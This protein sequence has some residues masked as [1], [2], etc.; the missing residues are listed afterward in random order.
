MEHPPAVVQHHALV[1]AA[2]RG[3]RTRCGVKPGATLLLA[4]SGGADSV[5][6][7][8]A[9]AALAPRRK[10][11]L[12][13][14]VGHVQHHLRD[15][16][17]NDAAFVEDL[18]NRLGLPF[19]RRDV[20]LDVIGNNLEAAAREA[21][22]AALGDMA[23]AA[24]ASAVVTAHHG[25]DQLE[26]ILMR[27][28]RGASPAAMAGMKWRRRL[29][30]GISL[31]RP[32]L[33]TDHETV[34]DYLRAI[35]QPWCEDETNTDLTRRRARLRRDVLPVLRALQPDAPEKA[36]RLAEQLRDVAA[37]LDEAVDEVDDITDRAAA[38]SLNRLVLTGALRRQL[39]AAGV[40][41]DALGSRELQPIVNA[42]RDRKGG[43]RTF[44]LAGGVSVEVDRNAIQITTKAQRAEENTEN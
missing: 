11:N 39:L 29:S 32:L 27:L 14:H 3:L 1:K 2:A 22:Y 40:P 18:A 4:V 34:L 8:R 23:K 20:V 36:V 38:R 5:A 10:W 15:S 21:R 35:D 43:T 31:V 7:L 33:L 13:L 28:L 24:G 17:E 19:T 26:T 16:A 25:D 9:V 41:A 12:T 6:L 37:L 42:I 30:H 44:D